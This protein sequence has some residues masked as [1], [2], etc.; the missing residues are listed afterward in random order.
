MV[1]DLTGKLAK[2][3]L[4]QRPMGT[5]LPA[6]LWLEIFVNLPP[7]DLSAA[8]LVSRQLQGPAYSLLFRSCVF[9]LEDSKRLHQMVAFYSSPRIAPGVHECTVLGHRQNCAADVALVCAALPCFVNLGHLEFQ[10]VRMTSTTIS[11]ISSRALT[12]RQSLSLVS[13][14]TDF[15][16]PSQ[17]QAGTVQVGRFLLHNEH[18]PAFPLDHHWLRL[19]RLDV[20]R[21]LDFALV[22]PTRIF[23]AELTNEPGIHLPTLEVLKLHLSGLDDL[24]EDD[25]VSALAS[26]PALHTLNLHPPLFYPNEPINDSIT[27]PAETLPLLSSFQGPSVHAAA[28]CAGRPLMHLKLYSVSSQAASVQGLLPAFLAIGQ[29]APRLRSLELRIACPVEDII[30][31]LSGALPSLRS[32][33]ITVLR[34]DSS[35]LT[36]PVFSTIVTG[37][38]ALVL[39]PQL[40]VLYLAYRYSGP[41]NEPMASAL[42]ALGRRSPGLQRISMCCDQVVNHWWDADSG[43]MLWRWTRDAHGVETIA[44]WT[45]AAP[46]CI[47]GRKPNIGIRTADPEGDVVAAALEQEWLD[48]TVAHRP[49][50]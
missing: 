11:A 45:A 44:H 15:P 2:L 14:M 36:Y 30:P 26:F 19:L 42:T 21:V 18:I 10:Y 9:I 7:S 29:A 48:A 8:S 33:R 20:V 50:T 24:S 27:L 37:L 23:I 43:T 41:H 28:Y 46:E 38:A 32:L 47:D 25:F 39:P 13:C 49:S 35:D 5:D 22:H 1:G 6:E 31:T 3:A 12:A 40:T 16:D 34:Y 4:V 17:G